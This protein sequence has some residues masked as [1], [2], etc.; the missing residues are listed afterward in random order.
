MPPP[1]P[2]VQSEAERSHLRQIKLL[3]EANEVPR[4]FLIW[5]TG[6]QLI[7]LLAKIGKPPFYKDGPILHE[8]LYCYNLD[9][10][11]YRTAEPR[12]PK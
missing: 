12:I 10:Y 5:I 7:A 4:P 11:R 3:L 1:A 9:T 6:A 2:Y 8:K